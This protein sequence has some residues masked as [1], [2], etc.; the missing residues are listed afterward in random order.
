MPNSH[1]SRQRQLRGRKFYAMVRSKNAVARKVLTDY[2]DEHK[3]FHGKSLTNFV[4][5]C[6]K[7]R[8]KQS[9]QKMEERRLP[10]RIWDYQQKEWCR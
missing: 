2:L 3:I 6:T 9:K 4:F 7:R 1:R 5:S 8:L 10:L